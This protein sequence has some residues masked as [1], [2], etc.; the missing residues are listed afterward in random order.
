M[1]KKFL[2]GIYI[3]VTLFVF[4][5][6]YQNTK[7]PGNEIAGNV[8][9]QNTA[10]P[11]PGENREETK[12]KKQEANSEAKIEESRNNK[13][14]DDITPAPS[15][16]EKIPAK[17]LWEDKGKLPMSRP[18]MNEE[19]Y[20]KYDNT[21][22]AWWITRKDH[23]EPSGSG[24]AFDISEYG[25]IYL[26]TQATQEDKVIYLTF[27]CGYENGNTPAILE[28]LKE[29]GATA[30]FFVTKNFV[31]SNP[32]LVRQMKAEGHNIGNH[33]VRHL[34][35]P[36]L[37]IAE[38]QQELTAVE[39]AVKEVTQSLPDAF[40]RPPSGDYSERVLKIVQDMGYNTVFW[41]IAYF[42]Y[43]T[44]NQPGEEFVADHFN[45]YHHSGAIPLIHNTSVSNRMAL[46]QVLSLLK[47]E[48]Y[49][50]GNLKEL[51]P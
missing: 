20:L 40:F 13:N 34:S 17:D 29:A 5:L 12:E 26:D 4:V 6:C 24:A 8:R 7:E 35:S 50:F 44:E 15:D 27:D 11:K 33:T 23:H 43:D 49:R 39:E 16:G 38:L 19:D 31:T 14:N 36:S 21:E 9:E 22:Y 30:T 45:T 51:V 37:S 47:E 42:D 48:G 10:S 25:A 2:E 3:A 18:V 1:K 32:D 46:P 28:A 41:S